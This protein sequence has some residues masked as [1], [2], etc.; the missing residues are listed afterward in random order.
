MSGEQDDRRYNTWHIMLKVYRQTL[1]IAPVTGVVALLFYLIDGLF[2]AV[3]VLILTALFDSATQFI[4]GE[5]TEHTV[6][7]YAALF[8][9]CFGVK[10]IIKFVSK[11]AIETGIYE[12]C[13][14]FAKMKLAQKAARLPLISYEDSEV[15]N[16]KTRAIACVDREA[17]GSIYMS[18]IGF[19][20]SAVGIV[21]L[22]A[23]LV[24]YHPL[25]IIIS[26]FSVLPNLIAR[27]IRGKNFYKTY[28]SQ[29]GKSRKLDYLWSL[30]A[31]RQAVKEMR[32]MGSEEYL[33]DEWVRIRD[34]ITE[35]VWE[36]GK[37]DTRSLLACDVVKVTGYA[38]SLVFAFYLVA[39]GQITVGLFASCISA[40]LSLQNQTKIFLIGLGG[41]PLLAS[42]AD[43]YYK[44]LD[45]PEE[46]DGVKSYPGLVRDIRMDGV[47]FTYP[48]AQHTS[49]DDVSFTV[50]KGQ[51]IAIL[52]ENGSGKT[53]LSKLLLGMY[54]PDEGTVT[55]D[56]VALHEYERSG[57]NKRISMIAQDFVTYNFSV[58]E[59]IAI[60]DV[61][62][63]CDDE[64]ILAA[65]RYVD[66]TDDVEA[67]GGLDGEL[68]REFG[69]NEFSGGQKQR[70]AIAR[71][72]FRES[73]LIV[74][75]EPT[76]ALDPLIEA[77]ILSSFLDVVRD[78]TAIIIS[79]R[80]GLCTL[81]DT[82]LVMKDGRIIESGDHE[83]L[84]R[85]GGEY[86]RLYR[87]QEQWYG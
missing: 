43:D 36:Q 12:K 67:G 26:L 53:T 50:E 66:L 41:Q 57:F 33:T 31:N 2:P 7:M 15:H 85:R 47:S 63:L 22:V 79:H 61:D 49:L 17:L 69:G 45:L 20:T 6:V 65:V 73:E 82:I 28:L 23:V 19:V 8:V 81:V 54:R 70:L 27:I 3:Q 30:F 86:S 5:Q 51:N 83:T 10:E 71:G 78:K 58:R 25:F 21:S 11:I 48:N 34:E 29:V 14:Y 9:I 56:G 4:Q 42:Y 76:S 18:S 75:D 39:T 40:F 24:G 68:G 74:L 13:S 55:Y 64:A 35:E 87:A 60:S 1:E 46:T 77:E 62:R 59:N 32:T 84:M 52:G 44:F 38:L 16:L 72:V 37:R 80:V